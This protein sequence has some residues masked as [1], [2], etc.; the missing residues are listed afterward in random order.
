MKQSNAFLDLFSNI[1]LL[2]I[3]TW[4]TAIFKIG[5]KITKFRKN[6]SSSHRERKSECAL[7]I[8]AL[9][10]IGSIVFEETKILFCIKICY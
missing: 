2:Y 8:P 3:S 4:K 6:M 9:C 5:L 10:D 7:H 1:C